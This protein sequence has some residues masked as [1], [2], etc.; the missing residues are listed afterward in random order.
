MWVS[1]FGGISPNALTPTVQ[2]A[3]NT[4][5]QLVS[6]GYD[7]AGN[8]SSD[9]QGGAYFYDCENKMTRCTVDGM[10]S[11]YSYDGNGRRITKTVNGPTTFTTLFVY[12]SGGQ[13][14]A[15]YGGPLPENG[16]TSYLTTDHLGST[17]VVTNSEEAVVAR[18]D[19][20]PF[21]EE[22]MLLAGGRTKPL[23]YTNTD[24]TRQKFT[25]KERDLESNLDFFEARYFS[26]PQGRFLSTDPDNAGGTAGN[27]QWWNAYI[28]AGNNPLRYTDPDGRTVRV[29]DSSGNYEDLSDEQASKY[30]FNKKYQQSLGDT[31]KNGKVTDA[32]GNV[33]GTYSRISF[34]D[35]TPQANAAIFG[36]A[37]RAHAMN[38]AIAT[39]GVGTVAVGA[40]GGAALYAT[41]AMTGGLTTLGLTETATDAET[42][43]Q[44]AVDANKLIHIF[45]KVEHN[46]ESLVTKFGSPETAF[47]AL[48]QATQ[49]TVE[50]QGLQ[51]VFETT[52]RVGAENVTVRG[53]VVN[54]VAKIGTA[55]IP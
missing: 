29:Y 32:N 46:L 26:A 10:Q 12:N 19:Y 41:E 7:P 31:V 35:L 52:V 15:E 37:A 50:K 42:A 40:T 20:L 11:T 23:G 6:S 13:L 2:S 3:Y 51:G 49:A 21:G 38:Q 55:F 16:G 8:Q 54:G 5:N 18:H 27:P 44:A 25:S 1:A 22:I 47:R 14:I 4:K 17:R 36:L 33:I 48:Q 9:N 43:G 24:D 28:Y 53:A 30:L 34:D 39:F 45:G